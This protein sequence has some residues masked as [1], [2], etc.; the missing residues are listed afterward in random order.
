MGYMRL[1]EFLNM[2]MGVFLPELY[3]IDGEEIVF[4]ELLCYFKK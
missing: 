4:V 2:P 3:Q 1:L